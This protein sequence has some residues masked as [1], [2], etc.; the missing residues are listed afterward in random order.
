MLAGL[1]NVACGAAIAMAGL[2][3]VMLANCVWIALFRLEKVIFF[4]AWLELD[5]W[6][7]TVMASSTESLIGVAVIIWLAARMVRRASK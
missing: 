2:L 4:G 3:A 1:R 7:N 6:K 5:R